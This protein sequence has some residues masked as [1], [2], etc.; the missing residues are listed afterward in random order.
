[1]RAH[2]I[3]GAS[4]PMRA[5]FFE[6]L[7]LFY[8]AIT[9]L[10]GI[11]AVLVD[12]YAYLLLSACVGGPFAL[13]ILLAK[14]ARAPL[15]TMYAAAAFASAWLAP[16][17]FFFEKDK[18]SQTG[19]QGT[20]KEFAFDSL[21]FVWSY[22]PVLLT[23]F[24]ALTFAILLL[25]LFAGASGAPAGIASGALYSAPRAT[26][27][28]AT[29]DA[30]RDWLHRGLLLILVAALCWLNVWMFNNG[31]GITGIEPP[32]LPFR[33]SGISYYVSR[34]VAPLLILW[35][36]LK[37][38]P[39]S[40]D[41][42]LLLGYAAFAAFTAVSRTSLI[43]LCIPVLLVVVR[44][45]RIVLGLAAL[46]W[47]AFIYPYLGFAR[48]FVYLADQGINIRN[49]D[50]SVLQVIGGSLLEKGEELLLAA[51]LAVVERVG[52]A[53]DVILAAQYDRDVAGGP[54][55]EFIRLYIFDFFERAAIAQAEMYDF[56]PTLRGFAVGDGGFFAHM[57]LVGGRD[58][59]ILLPLSAY[60]GALLAIGESV[61]RRLEAMLVPAEVVVFYSLLFNI[62][63]FALSIP[64]WFNVFLIMT[65]CGVRSR[66]VRNTLRRVFE[67]EGL[68]GRAPVG[69][70]GHQ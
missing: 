35:L 26:R 49:V 5:G 18:F 8:L 37:F 11:H 25:R 53:Q 55:M 39:T 50:F 12:Q 3:A 32:A 58:V 52:G 28:A 27:A 24:L 48:N 4:G 16:L 57:L 56:A 15:L 46:A 33:L 17:G 1:M 31:I 14:A 40:L 19:G 61:R 6:W 54:L 68:G 21:Q 65:F 47:V 69:Q 36:L 42:A 64:L 10:I 70:A 43:L 38:R 20:V 45:R 44:D 30:G 51:P 9:A 23:H 66:L 13:G 62:L 22:Q 63:F 34:F 2:A 59:E 29:P 60:L 41:L 67:S 7:L